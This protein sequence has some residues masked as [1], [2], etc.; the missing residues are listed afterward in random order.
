MEQ[1]LYNNKNNNNKRHRVVLP[2]SFSPSCWLQ[3]WSDRLADSKVRLLKLPVLK[4]MISTQLQFPSIMDQILVYNLFN[5]PSP[6]VMCLDVM[7]MSNRGKSFRKRIIHVTTQFMV[8]FYQAV[9]GLVLAYGPHLS[10]T[11]PRHAETSWKVPGFLM[12]A[13]GRVICQP[14]MF[15]SDAYIWEKET[16]NHILYCIL[17]LLS[18]GG[19]LYPNIDGSC[20]VLKGRVDFWTRQNDPCC[21]PSCRHIGSTCWD[22]ATPPQDIPGCSWC[23]IHWRMTQ[24]H[25]SPANGSLAGFLFICRFLV[26]VGMIWIQ[27]NS[28]SEAQRKSKVLKCFDPKASK[29]SLVHKTAG[30]E[31][32]LK[33][34]FEDPCKV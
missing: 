10:N 6:L 30:A 11:A 22:N 27:V 13:W 18:P 9:C 3:K 2:C 19:M 28:C 16:K 31:R 1:V 20:H 25:R 4:N 14:R 24:G 34:G 7:T 21:S 17:I 32:R 26:C 15:K 23:A 5:E 29:Q 33:K 12:A 8:D